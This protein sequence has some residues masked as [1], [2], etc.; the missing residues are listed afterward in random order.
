MLQIRNNV[1]ETNSS[2][3]HSLCISKKEP[4]INTNETI[5]FNL[6]FYGWEVNTVDM[7][8]YIYTA[9]VEASLDNKKEYTYLDKFKNILS[10][11][12]IKFFLEE[13]EI[14][15]SEFGGYEYLMNGGIDH[16]YELKDFLDAIFEN[17]QLFLKCIFNSDSVVHTGNDNGYYY[18]FDEDNFIEK[19]EDENFFY[20]YKGN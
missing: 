13:P 20:F 1:F 5:Y 16:D 4:I 17:E 9:V 2:S 15:I 8:D 10:K 11:Y 14:K 19:G 3:T 7:R 18:P 12:N 6:G